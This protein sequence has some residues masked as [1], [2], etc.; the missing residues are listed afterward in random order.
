MSLTLPR[1]RPRVRAPGAGR[2]RAAVVAI[3][4]GL[5]VGLVAASIFTIQQ[6]SREVVGHAAS[7]HSV[8]ETLRAVTVTRS[9][10]AFAAYL[11]SVDERF[12]TDSSLVIGGTIADARRGIG[13]ARTTIDSAPAGSPLAEPRAR[14]LVRTFTARAEGI[15]AL[16]ESGR[17][18]AARRA[19]ERLDTAFEE[20]RGDLV[21]RRDRALTQIIA[22]DDRLWRVGA[23]A[24]FVAAFIVPCGIVFVYM[25]LTRR[26][27]TGVE[28]EVARERER[29]VRERRR[30]ATEAAVRDLRGAIMESRRS[31]APVAMN[32]LDDLTGLLSACDGSVSRRFAPVPMAALLEDVV[33]AEE[34]AGTEIVL[35]AGDEAAWADRD[36]LRHVAVNLIAEAR[37]AGARRVTLQSAL[38]DDQVQL[39]VMHDGAPLARE[40]ARVLGGA[41]ADPSPGAQRPSTRILAVVAVSE[42]IDAALRAVSEPGPALVLRIASAGSPASPGRR[43][44]PVTAPAHA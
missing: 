38:V 42:S 7:L 1:L 10:V 5:V 32:V 20:I 23:L 27:R 36:A 13:D 22:D 4:C 34:L 40:I 44:V 31:G 17:P 28:A 3:A 9:Q 29:A 37:A 8:D 11:A 16:V 14:E 25:A 41:P 35:R 24:S 21:A 43:P 30:E 19:T 26:S 12:R 33:E 39:A 6:S 15:L 18:A 2:R